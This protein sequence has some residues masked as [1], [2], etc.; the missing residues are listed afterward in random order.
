LCTRFLFGGNNRK[1]ISSR[2]LSPFRVVARRVRPDRHQLPIGG[3]SAAVESNNRVSMSGRVCTSPDIDRH[4]G[5]HLR[6]RKPR[7]FPTALWV[8]HVGTTGYTFDGASRC[9][10]IAGPNGT[11]SY[12]F[13]AASRRTGMT[14]TGTGSWAYTWDAGNRLSTVTTPYSEQTSYSYDAANRTTSVTLGNSAVTSYSS[15]ASP[16]CTTRTPA[17]RPW[18][19][20]STP[21][22]EHQHLRILSSLRLCASHLS[23]HGRF[24]VCSRS[25][26]DRA[27]RQI[28]P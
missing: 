23:S 26:S 14:L 17:A 21:T 11:V 20:T 16:M 25:R 15:I 24:R 19:T 10:Q 3:G 4:N 18:R 7:C 6:W 12:A 1:V 28:R 5:I 8:I 9:T 27:D 13:D 2:C 22:T